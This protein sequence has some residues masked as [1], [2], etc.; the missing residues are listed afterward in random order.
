MEKKK[1]TLKGYIKAINVSLDKKSRYYKLSYSDK[2][3]TF[4]SESAKDLND[5]VENYYLKEDFINASKLLNDL[6]VFKTYK[7]NLQAETDFNQNLYDYIKSILIAFFSSVITEFLS[8]KIGIIVLKVSVQGLLIFITINLIIW[9]HNRKSH[10]NYNRLKDV[11]GVIHILEAIKEEIYN[12]PECRI[13]DEKDE[14]QDIEADVSI[15][16]TKPEDILEDTKND[17]VIDN[18]ATKV[19][20]IDHSN[21]SDINFIKGASCMA[22]L[23]LSIAKLFGKKK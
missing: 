12:N 16:I 14:D 13:E 21:K 3:T 1:N 22:V 23:L 6:F 9:E 10:S 4:E 5:Y 17:S 19:E 8:S 7:E 18:E 20:I 15:E 2:E 11:N